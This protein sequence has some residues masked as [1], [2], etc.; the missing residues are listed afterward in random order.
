MITGEASVSTT[1]L[2]ADQN[3]VYVEKYRELITRLFGSPER[4]AELYSI[5]LRISPQSIRGH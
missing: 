4:F 3:H 1:D 5:A 2:P